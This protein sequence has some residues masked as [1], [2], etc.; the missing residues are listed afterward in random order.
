MTDELAT[1]VVLC[2]MEGK[3][4]E[5]E[6]L[7]SVEYSEEIYEVLLPCDLAE[8]NELVPVIFK[9]DATNEKTDYIP[10]EDED[11]LYDVFDIFKDKYKNE[12]DFI[13]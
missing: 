2:D 11:V 8:D 12:F 10:V 4:I 5:F 3:E 13:D 7:G 6:V 1:I 9:L